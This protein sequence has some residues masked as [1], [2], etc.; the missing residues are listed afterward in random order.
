MTEESRERELLGLRTEGGR[1]TDLRR[2][3][4]DR[5]CGVTSPDAKIP[6]TETAGYLALRR[7]R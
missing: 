3:A 1:E 7:V 4:F 5:R 6:G 2:S